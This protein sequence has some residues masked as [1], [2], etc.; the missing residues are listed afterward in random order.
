M[1][2]CDSC[3][4][5][6]ST[7]FTTHIG[8]DGLPVVWCAECMKYDEE[9]LSSLKCVEAPPLYKEH[10]VK[11]TIDEVEYPVDKVKFRKKHNI[12]LDA[13]LTT[14][15]N[16]CS[17]PRINFLTRE[18]VDITHT[19]CCGINYGCE[20]PSCDALRNEESKKAKISNQEW[21]AF[22]ALNTQ[23]PKAP[24]KSNREKVKFVISQ[25]YKYMSANPKARKERS[26]AMAREKLPMP[27]QEEIERMR[28]QEQ[29]ERRD[30]KLIT[31]FRRKQRE[32]AIEYPNFQKCITK[33]VLCN[34]E[35]EILN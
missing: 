31:Q 30:K 32:W 5:P 1:P 7:P 21:I 33:M 23:V 6:L 13:V 18:V 35:G 14:N 12:P 25:Y 27:S 29:K 34:A 9:V 3:S 15:K 19:F 26:V 10:E 16:C 11:S 20:C 22:V 17:L 24:K 4:Q 28:R 8:E 2:L